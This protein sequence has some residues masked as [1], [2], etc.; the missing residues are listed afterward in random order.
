M[1]VDDGHAGTLDSH[2]MLVTPTW[3]AEHLDD[4]DLVVVDLRWDEQGLGRT[5]YEQGHIPGA[6]FLDWATDLVDP[7][8]EVAFML[9][10]PERFA[11]EL[12]RCGISDETVVVAYADG[13][14]SGPFRLWWGCRTYGHDDQVRILDGGIEAWVAEGR[15]L[16][17]KT[18]EAARGSWTPRS[19]PV[20]VASA[21]DVAAAR[22]GA[23]LVLDSREPSKFRGETVWFETGE[24]P[25]D[26]DGVARTPR[27][28]LRAGRVPWA[29]SVP[30]QELYRPDL[31]M[32]S[33]AE[34]RDLF[35][36]LG[37]EPGRPA[38]TYCGVGI[39]ASA[40]LYAL[41]RAGFEDVSLYDAGWDEWG[42]DP[43]LPVAHG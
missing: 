9:A 21:Q 31:T 32:K 17:Q 28:D 8:H 29:S 35:A 23:T 2:L 4:P 33:P 20:L 24:I 12:A 43:K 30:S 18:P 10:P 7:D 26:D 39:S 25:T 14:H 5:R 11:A 6:H 3:L 27:G 19:G 16:S 42:R 34:L 40:L 37:A 38:I 22:D 41:N 15:P 13:G 36:R 1:D